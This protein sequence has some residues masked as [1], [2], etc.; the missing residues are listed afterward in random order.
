MQV[1]GGVAHG[2]HRFKVRAA[3]ARAYWTVGDSPT[4]RLRARLPVQGR[5]SDF[6]KGFWK[7]CD[8]SAAPGEEYSEK[9]VDAEKFAD[10]QESAKAAGLEFAIRLRPLPEGRRWL[11]GSQNQQA[12][13]PAAFFV[14][15]AVSLAGGL[16]TRASASPDQEHSPLPPLP[17][18]PKLR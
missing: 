3:P 12:P 11:S 13:A 1:G 6:N 2:R 16:G 15:P 8:T 9:R 4:P 7:D 5:Q 14:L 18:D 17:K 10:L